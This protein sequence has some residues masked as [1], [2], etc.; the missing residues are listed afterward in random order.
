MIKE[1]WWTIVDV[2][3]QVVFDMIIDPANLQRMLVG[4]LAEVS[5]VA[6]LPDGGYTYT[7]HYRWAGLPMPVIAEAAMT[8][9]KR[10]EKIV[11]ES[12]GGMRTISTWRFEPVGEKQ[13]KATFGIEAPDVNSLLRRLSGRFIS[14]QLRF[15]VDTALSNIRHMTNTT[16]RAQINAWEGVESRG[17]TLSI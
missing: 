8:E 11:I 17:P 14:N 1:E 6:P 12:T 2:P 4:N 13:T 9:L 15:A 16:I 5:D 3:P 7:W 10:Y